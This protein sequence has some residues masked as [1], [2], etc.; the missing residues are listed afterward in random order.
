MLAATYT[1]D[2]I[3]DA[4][5]RGRGRRRGRVIYIYSGYMYI[6]CYA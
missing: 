6:C 1:I 5:Q 4:S 3:Y 2:I